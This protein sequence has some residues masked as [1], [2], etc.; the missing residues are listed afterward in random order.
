MA[1]VG[2]SINDQQLLLIDRLVST[3]DLRVQ[4]THSC[5]DHPLV[6]TTQLHQPSLAC[7]IGPMCIEA[8][9]CIFYAYN[10]FSGTS[11]ENGTRQ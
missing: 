2:D 11:T 8:I 5:Y 3:V 4:T 7:T 6:T 9:G 1:I 10:N